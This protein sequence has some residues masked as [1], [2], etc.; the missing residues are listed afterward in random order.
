MLAAAAI[1]LAACDTTVTNP[2]PV[3]DEDLNTPLAYDA[4]VTGGRLALARAY[5]SDAGFGGTIAYWGAA[6]SFE[7]NPAGSTG[8]FG[9]PTVIQAGTMTPEL[10]NAEWSA[11]NLARFVA[12]DAIRRF[13]AIAA[14]DPDAA[15][16]PR[17]RSE[18]K[19]YAGYAHRLLG[20]TF[21]G[22]VLP[23]DNPD[24]SVSPGDST[25][26]TDYFLRAEQHFTDAIQIAAGVTPDTVRER[27]IRA[28]QAARA[29]V[30]LDLAAWGVGGT[31]MWDDAAADA[32]AIPDTFA[33]RLPFSAQDQNQYNY[34]YW[35]RGDSPYRAHTQ[36]ST[37]FEGYYRAT[38]AAGTPDVRAAWDSTDL[39][40]DAAV[41]R[42]GGQVPFWPEAKH[43]A[44]N[45][46]INL[47]SGWEMR[48]VE[49]E[50][51]LVAGNP[52]PAVDLIN[53]RRTD[54]GLPIYDNGVAIDSAWSILKVERGV[55]LWLEA[56]R[57]GDLRR[58]IVNAVPGS[59]PDGL[60]RL[61]TSDPLSPVPLE[62]MTTPTARSLCFP[63][64]QNEHD[65]N[66][67]L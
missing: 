64:G 8:S 61:N 32:A 46:P 39:L 19:L 22:A 42:F 63:I 14:A 27:I 33:F 67:N 59:Y 1:L 2:G 52:G 28:A 4:I 60:Y 62:N 13:D 41:A 3:P 51:Q 23:F 45:S 54:L 6:L 38:R 7:I 43:D 66:P 10:S 34:I 47:S 37:Y 30:R 17:Q 40:G 55:E 44:R 58:W 9:I 25:A 21:C 31:T 20:E 35:A 5:G 56:R 48:L 15:A 36:W 12:E 11:A 53:L 50:R 57:L 29:S 16:T 18:A 49:A 65:T 24:G 26:H